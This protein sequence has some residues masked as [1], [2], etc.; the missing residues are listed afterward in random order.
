[1]LFYHVICVHMVRACL[2]YIHISPMQP[3][4]KYKDDAM[5]VMLHWFIEVIWGNVSNSFKSSNREENNQQ[6]KW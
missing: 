3:A 4:S 1:M 2:Y 6:G 5:E